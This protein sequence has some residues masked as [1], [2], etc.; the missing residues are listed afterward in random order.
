MEIQNTNTGAAASSDVIVGNNNT[1]STTYY[2]DFGMN[3]SGWAGT[4]AF[5]APNNV[6]LTATSGDLAIGTT[7][8]NQ[9]RFAVNGNTT[10]SATISSAG[11]FS[12]ANDATIHGVTVGQGAGSVSTNTAVGSGALSTNSS[13]SGNLA[14]GIN[15][16]HNN[17][18]GF[19]NSFVGASAGYYVTSNYNTALG[20][21]AINGNGTA[22]SGASNT[23]LGYSALFNANTGTVN[24]AVGYN[25]GYSITT[26]SYN[27]I[28]GAYTGSAAPISASGSNYIVVSDGAGNIG[29]YW[30]GTNGNMFNTG[31]VTAPILNASNGIVVNSKTIATSYTIPSGSNANS[32][33]PVT[34]AS[35]QS[36]TVSSGSRWVVL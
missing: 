4:G 7:T 5:T 28:I 24:T 29:A 21:N 11:I 9:I 20:T 2:G 10:D 8:S 17:S 27:T 30:T 12:T 34:V 36:V 31:T 23:G 15:A 14:V 1:T 32:V 26:G 22:V 6:Y 19:N 3:S 33:G 25:S 35:G 18:T 13:G 16:L